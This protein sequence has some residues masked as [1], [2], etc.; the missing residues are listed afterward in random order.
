MSHL[1]ISLLG[2][3]R[4]I[5]D[6]VP[7]V[8][9]ETN[10]VRA[11]LAFLMV[12]ADRPHRRETLA[13]LLWSDL[14]P[15]AA[16]NN[17]RQT[18]YRL[19]QVIGDEAAEPHFLSVTVNEIQFNTNSDHWLDI[20]A[21]DALLAASQKHHPHGFSLCEECIGRLR[22]AISLYQGDFLA[23]FSLS[24]CPQFDWWL[25][26]KQEEYHRKAL[27]ALSKSGKFYALRRNY[28]QAAELAQNEIELEPWRESAHRRLMR[29]LALSGQRTQ[30]LRQYQLCRQ[31]LSKDLG[32]EPSPETQRLYDQIRS[33]KRIRFRAKAVEDRGSTAK[34]TAKPASLNYNP[35]N[36]PA[37]GLALPAGRFFDREAELALLYRYLGAMINSQG[38]V[39]FISGEAG[40]GKSTLMS[41]FSRQAMQAYENLLSAWGSGNAYAGPGD[42]YLPFREAIRTLL[43][44]TETDLVRGRLTQEHVLR[45][46]TAL[47]EVVQTMFEKGP[48][49][50]NAFLL[51][52]TLERISERV[53]GFDDILPSH[54]GKMLERQ[55]QT[56]RKGDAAA[57]LTEEMLQLALANP[58]P[59][60][61]QRGALLDQITSVLR[62]LARRHPLVLMLDDLQWIDAPTANLLFHLG[63]RLPG[64]RILIVCAYRPEDLILE[65]GAPRH[66]LNFVVNELQSIYGDI[67]V[68]LN[69]ADGE[70]LVEAFLD[71]EANLL[72]QDFRQAF[73]Q[74]S[75][76]NPLF[77]LEL[78]RGFKERGEIKPDKQ[79]R[80]VAGSELNWQA[81][82][83]KI[84]AVIAERLS[85]LPPEWRDLL[86]CASVQGQT[87]IAEAAALTAGL[88]V[89]EVLEHLSGA[90]S[91]QHRL[92]AALHR[93]S[94]GETS[95]SVYR[96]QNKLYQI[97]LYNS[98][99]AVERAR[100][101]ER[102]KEMLGR[103]QVK[104]ET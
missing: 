58:S 21:F 3:F 69:L 15:A 19:R 62:S 6:G 26:R 100:L 104:R 28:A 10:K 23:G 52:G 13:A 36:P 1:A 9:F 56:G 14:P 85:H 34:V 102:S 8:D 4:A 98:L 49:L 44:D 83:A 87:F 2:T 55:I 50:L 12:E 84:E 80:W 64:S 75:G 97:Y 90:L 42:P 32:I 78:L 70:K 38:Q 94:S 79:G 11:L 60:G 27:A 101:E 31:I 17:L 40:S 66:P 46:Q 43:G 45:V 59:A 72:D 63:K 20:A 103:M 81:L 95:S 89:E 33:G 96:F 92:V 22:S 65:T 71:S 99:D 29:A 82:P 67:Q 39:V 47:P 16:R 88:E 74:H 86:A 73:F 41:A 54:M 57:P 25:L 77:A 7:L 53:G 30:A 48:D 68:D 35:L 24:N 91:K 76:G 93:Q 61:P 18:L 5:L 37:A 51:P